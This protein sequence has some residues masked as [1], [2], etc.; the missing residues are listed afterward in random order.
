MS[1]KAKATFEIVFEPLGR[2]IRTIAGTTLLDAARAVGIQIASLCGGAG[3]CE[4][5]IV[6]LRTG[7]LS[8][9]TREELSAREEGRLEEGER[10][11]CQASPRS[12]VTIEIPTSSLLTQQR[13]QLE[14][15]V[16]D[17]ALNP[18]TRVI[19]LAIDP[20][21]L[22]L[23]ESD[24]VRVQA[25]LAEAG[26]PNVKCDFPLIE[27]LSDRLRELA[28]DVR[29]VLREDELIT[30]LPKG[31][32]QLG[33]AVDL[34]TTKLAVYLIDLETGKTLGQAGAMNPQI[35]FGEDVISRISYAN[36]GKQER[37]E[38]KRV[39]VTTL[40]EII[41][42]LCTS[43]GCSSEAI[44]EAVV[45]GNTA[46]HH[47]FLGL[48]LR[49]LGVSPYVPAVGGSLQVHSRDLGLNFAPGS[50]VYLPPNIAGFVGADHS[51]VLLATGFGQ[52]RGAAMVVDIGTNTEISLQVG[53]KIY[54]CSCASGPAFEGAHI[55]DGM[56]ASSGAIERVQASEGGLR[57]QTVEDQPPVGLCGSGILD[58]VAALRSLGWVDR[59]GRISNENIKNQRYHYPE[60]IRLVSAEESGHGAEIV[61][62]REDIHEIQ[63]AQGAIRA[64]IEV[65]L[66]QAG[67]RMD[68]LEC[69]YLAGAFGTYLNLPS[70]IQLGMLPEIELERT[71][72]I[73]NAAGEGARHLL[74][75]KDKRL[76]IAGILDRV[77]YIELTTHPGFTD[78]YMKYL[79]LG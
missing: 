49:Q 48:P 18:P 50:Y 4:S 25:A 2:R 61:I 26:I 44:V 16:S 78:L 47:A 6:R 3:L 7:D 41:V 76:E 79:Y 63:L 35:P 13:L 54:S 60:G 8:S 33:I 37:Q 11:A 30:I 67:L 69:L 36:Q 14:G 40:N 1:K 43:I 5:C 19:N 77:E 68:A 66:E 65:L 62:T 29:L 74:L 53:E 56:R 42:E 24:L 45:V 64:G 72:Q 55:R 57:W 20:P 32:A 31:Q 17:V 71:Q 52:I 58:A 34:G 38:L 28:W 12:D 51:A 39:V 27:T 22:S 75:S 9:P 21:S 70:A 59:S 15:Q 10:L 73:G 46:M 23:P